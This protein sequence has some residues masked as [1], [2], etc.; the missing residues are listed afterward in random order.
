MKSALM[1]NIIS[2][3]VD[4]IKVQQWCIYTARDSCSRLTIYCTY[5][6]FVSKYH[7]RT[8]EN[9]LLVNCILMCFIGASP[10]VWWLIELKRNASWSVVRTYTELF[11][12]WFKSYRLFASH[13]LFW[14]LSVLQSTVIYSKFYGSFAISP[15]DRQFFMRH[16]MKYILLAK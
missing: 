10:T 13:R 7:L 5:P 9:T 8:V 15:A 12:Q 2:L 16:A 11:L 3:N 4:S 6:V 14:E 1:S